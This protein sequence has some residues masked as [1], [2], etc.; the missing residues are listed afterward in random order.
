M[1]AR[2]VSSPQRLEEARARRHDAHVAG[3]RLDDDRG[4]LVAARAEQLAH[5]VG[6]VEVGASASSAASAAG[7]PGLSGTP[8]VSGAGP[9]RT[10]SESTWPW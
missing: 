2:A 4:D 1:P 3:D 8:S 10:R 5:A 7:T 9:G 6:V